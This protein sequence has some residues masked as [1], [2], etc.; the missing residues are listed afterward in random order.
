[1]KP[2]LFALLL[3]GGAVAAQPPTSPQGPTDP[4]IDGE[5]MTEPIDRP[6][7]DEPP[8]TDPQ[9][10][11]STTADSEVFFRF[12]S[13]ELTENGRTA[14]LN[15]VE[16][17][18]DTSGTSLVLDAHADAH[19]PAPYNVALS[20]RRAEAVR[21]FLTENGYPQERV[22]MTMYGE[23][24]PRRATLAQDRRVS[25]TLTAEP[26]HSIIDRAGPAATAVVW[27]EPVTIAEI[28]GPAED[29]VP[30]TAWR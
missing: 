19:G 13:A 17:A 20:V 29:N 23:D 15:L 18:K 27:H 22:V 1:M 12:D 24:A 16:H 2:Y 26:L 21:E 3:Y 4:P 28:D 11:P 14:L 9:P 5:P 10:A 30:Q 25:V 7:H 6:I 8:P